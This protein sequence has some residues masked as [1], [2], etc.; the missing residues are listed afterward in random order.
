VDYQN[1]GPRDIS[2]ALWRKAGIEPKGRWLLETDA[3]SSEEAV[4]FAS[5]HA[6]YLVLGRLPTLPTGVEILTQGD[7]EMH[8]SFV[9]M[10]ANPKR[11]AAAN[12]RAAR[13]LSSF[14][15]SRKG[16]ELLLRFATNSPPGFPLFWPVR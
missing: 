2:D 9:V 4:D 12:T 7:P 13:A 3:S 8:R 11:L 6:A 15:L 10:E 14:L 1:S 16:Q 5:S